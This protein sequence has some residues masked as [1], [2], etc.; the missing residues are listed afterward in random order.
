MPFAR[1]A[2]IG[3]AHIPSWRR[4]AARQAACQSG[5]EVPMIRSSTADTVARPS[6]IGCAD[7]RCPSLLKSKV[8]LCPHRAQPIGFLRSG[9]RSRRGHRATA[10]H[11]ATGR[12]TGQSKTPTA[13]RAGLMAT[14]GTS[15]AATVTGATAQ[16]L[17]APLGPWACM[18]RSGSRLAKRMTPGH[19][20]QNLWRT[21]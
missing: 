21:A 7:G 10:L 5:A 6:P 15:C 13:R 3:G 16:R 1:T 18:H 14:A 11:R 8:A 17:I 9:V 4:C 2:F 20:L 19:P 12:K